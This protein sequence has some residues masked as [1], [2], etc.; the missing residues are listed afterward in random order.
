M[1]PKQQQ[2]CQLHAAGTAA[3]EAYARVYGCKQKSAEVNASKLLAKDH[4]I[5]EVD[6]LRKLAKEKADADAVL[7]INE[8]R[9]LLARI[10]RTSVVDLDPKDKATR[11]LIKKVSRKMLGSGEA[12]YEVEE[13]E[14]YD[15]LRVIQL[16]TELAGDGASISNSSDFTQF[17][18]SLPSTGMIRPE[19]KM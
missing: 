2:F 12:A 14:G 1:N 16:D 11:D 3:P 15:K 8:K 13:I 6:R 5:A 18:K 19:D 17:L 4:I 10:A 9:I 7:S